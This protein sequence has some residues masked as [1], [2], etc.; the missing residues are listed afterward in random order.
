MS[1]GAFVFASIE[2][3]SQME[4]AVIAQNI[5]YVAVGTIVEFSTL[6]TLEANADPEPQKPSSLIVV[7]YSKAFL[8]CSL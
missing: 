6:G 1:M 3:D 2:A 8:E 5:R 7:K 4:Q